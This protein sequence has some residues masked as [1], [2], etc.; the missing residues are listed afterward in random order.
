L[1]YF[2]RALELCAT[3]MALLGIRYRHSPARRPAA[4]R[5]GQVARA[6]PRGRGPPH[7]QRLGA[8]NRRHLAAPIGQ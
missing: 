2:E 8:Y 4:G 6:S 7:R 1:A 5:R 3:R